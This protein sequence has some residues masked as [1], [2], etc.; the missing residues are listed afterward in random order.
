MKKIGYL[1]LLYTGMMLI[2]RIALFKKYGSY[3]E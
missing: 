2:N 1:K 3:N